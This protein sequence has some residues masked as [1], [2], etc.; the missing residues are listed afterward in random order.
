[1]NPDPINKSENY[2]LFKLFIY[3]LL[4]LYR[5]CVQLI[6]DPFS[7]FQTKTIKRNL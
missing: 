7:T 4:Y 5:E 3:S 6:E 1:M 2:P